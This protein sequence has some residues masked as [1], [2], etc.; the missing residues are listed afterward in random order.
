M[1][2]SDLID[3]KQKGVAFERILKAV[4]SGLDHFSNLPDDQLEFFET[5]VIEVKKAVVELEHSIRSDDLAKVKSNSESLI[6]IFS[7]IR[8]SC[9]AS[10]ATH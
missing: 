7:M 4:E 8:D 9:D 2:A 3:A 1:K 5:M 10:E 6:E